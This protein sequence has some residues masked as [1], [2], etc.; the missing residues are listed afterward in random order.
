MRGRAGRDESA[1]LAATRPDHGDRSAITK[2]RHIGLP[3]GLRPWSP[4]GRTARCFAAKATGTSEGTEDSSWSTR[5][6]QRLNEAEAPTKFFNAAMATRRQ[7]KLKRGGPDL[8]RCLLMRRPAGRGE[9]DSQAAA[10]RSTGLFFT[11]DT[12]AGAGRQDQEPVQRQPRYGADPK[13]TVNRYNSCGPRRR[14]GTSRKPTPLQNDAHR[15]RS[16]AAW[17]TAD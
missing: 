12:L 3:C 1:I 14:Q 17:S 4:R 15:R 16:S 7:G 11:P 10:G 2:T 13:E 9:V 6:G 5:S 8:G